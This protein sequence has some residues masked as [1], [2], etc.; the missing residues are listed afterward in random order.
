[1]RERHQIVEDNCAP[2]DAGVTVGSIGKAG[3]RWLAV[4]FVSAALVAWSGAYVQHHYLNM[5]RTL[6]DRNADYNQETVECFAQAVQHFVVME[7]NKQFDSLNGSFFST[8]ETPDDIVASREAWNMR[9]FYWATIDEAGQKIYADVK[10]S[11]DQEAHNAHFVNAFRR[12][13]LTN[14]LGLASLVIAFGAVVRL[15]ALRMRAA[16]GEVS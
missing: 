4:L 14:G 2:P 10:A 11:L 8:N 15:W 9:K 7:F 3:R 16:R 13:E 12:I 6:F 1:M 5:G